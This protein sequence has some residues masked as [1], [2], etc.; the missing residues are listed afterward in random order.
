MLIPVTVETTVDLK[1]PVSFETFKDARYDALSYE[2]LGMEIKLRSDTSC[3]VELG[4]MTTEVR[5]YADDDVMVRKIDI[6]IRANADSELKALAAAI[7]MLG[8]LAK[9]YN[10]LARR[11]QLK[12]LTEVRVNAGMHFEGNYHEV[13]QDIGS[14]MFNKLP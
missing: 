5:V 6:E 11:I 7:T 3:W 4:G 9:V 12:E 10:A 13:V 8:I 2:N 14:I 1:W